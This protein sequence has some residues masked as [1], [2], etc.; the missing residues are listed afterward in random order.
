MVDYEHINRTAFTRR[1]R[2]D[3]M[4]ATLRGSIEGITA[5]RKINAIE[6]GH[7][8][9]WL[10]HHADLGMHSPYGELF[11]HIQNALDDLVLTS[12][13]KEEILAGIDAI[14]RPQYYDSLTTGLQ[15]L[16]AMVAAIAVDREVNIEEVNGLRGW[17]SDH[18]SLKSHWPYDEVDTLVTQVLRDR[19]IDEVEHEQLKAYFAAFRVDGRSIGDLPT[20]VKTGEALFST[21][22][23]IQFEDRTFC[24][25]GASK[26]ATRRK[27]NECIEQAG[28]CPI[29][30]VTND[31]HYLIVC[32]GGNQAWA[33]SCY[34]RK[35]ESAI[36]VRRSGGTL[37]LVRENDL[38]D[39]LAD[40]GIELPRQ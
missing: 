14:G 29:G 21:E 25:T 24:L 11:T 27:I 34:G 4:L 8:L 3:V 10:E 28:G 12:E 31:L 39:G 1:Q 36:E 38:W 35:V 30:N 37:V 5:D 6:H 15:E 18:D 26:R 13:E 9:K 19:R 32:D 40:K 23:D 22:P 20:S 2:S 16:Q 7:L 33:F 17:L